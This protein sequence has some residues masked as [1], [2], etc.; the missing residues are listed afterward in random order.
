MLLVGLGFFWLVLIGGVFFCCSVGTHQHVLYVCNLPRRR[1]AHIQERHGGCVDIRIVD[2]VGAVVR[3]CTNSTAA[4]GNMVTTIIIIINITT[5][6]ISALGRGRL[7]LAL[8]LS[9][10]I[11]VSVF[12]TSCEILYRWFLTPDTLV[13]L[14]LLPSPPPVLLVP[15]RPVPG[16]LGIALGSWCGALIFLASWSGT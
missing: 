14:L 11:L 6:V 12:F 15:L 1:V 9:S 10:P 2:L 16:A 13:L 3:R 5:T 7:L 4:L 8:P